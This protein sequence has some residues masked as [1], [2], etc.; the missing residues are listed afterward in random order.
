MFHSCDSS[1][2]VFPAGEQLCSWVTWGPR[3]LLSLIPLSLGKRGIGIP[4]GIGILCLQEMK[5]GR[6]ENTSVSF[7]LSLF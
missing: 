6:M 7:S 4:R 3:I 1:V 2:Q 5:K